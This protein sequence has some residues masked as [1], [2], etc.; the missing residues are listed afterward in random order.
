MHYN[1]LKSPFWNFRH[2]AIQ[3]ETELL[4]VR[5]E[6]GLDSINY[7]LA[8]ASVLS[9]DGKVQFRT[10]VRTEPNRTER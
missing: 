5:K 8:L 7:G 9:S 10:A 1:K 4:R 6:K 3:L 2:R